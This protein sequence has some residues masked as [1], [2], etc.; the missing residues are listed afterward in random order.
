MHERNKYLNTGGR[1]W[2][3]VNLSVQTG[4]WAVMTIQ[5]NM[6]A[7]AQRGTGIKRRVGERLSSTSSS[8]NDDN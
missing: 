8:S 7:R 2:K 5:L 4:R 1:G 3:G 6:T